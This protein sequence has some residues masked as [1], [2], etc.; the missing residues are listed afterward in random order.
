MPTK[1]ALSAD[2]LAE[3]HS[4]MAAGWSRRDLAQKFAVGVTTINRAAAKAPIGATKSP[5]HAGTFS[6]EELDD[7]RGEVQL[8]QDQLRRKD[9]P[10]AGRA[11]LMAQIR[12]HRKQ[13]SAVEAALANRGSA[14]DPSRPAADRVRAKLEQ[15]EAAAN[16]PVAV[17]TEGNG[18]DG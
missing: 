4:L 3:I 2:Q 16:G 6:G 11:A 1:S 8:A 13:I 12:A 17:K 18:T 7:L 10:A 9:L 14:E 5:K 15:M